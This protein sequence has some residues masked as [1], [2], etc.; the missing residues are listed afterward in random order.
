MDP[1]WRTTQN[2]PRRS[3]G[4]GAD[5]NKTCQSVTRIPPEKSRTWLISNVRRIP[6]YSLLWQVTTRTIEKCFELLLIIRLGTL[7]TEYQC[8]Y[9]Y[10][11]DD[12][13]TE[14]GLQREWFRI[15]TR[16]YKFDKLGKILND[17]WKWGWH[18]VMLYADWG[19]HA[20]H[21]SLQGWK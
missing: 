4:I 12:M 10:L 9:N 8:F 16:L 5:S 13:K 20:F 3:N 17:E 11:H 6:S 2:L 14:N 15:G 18:E 7:G 19:K 21:F 1:N